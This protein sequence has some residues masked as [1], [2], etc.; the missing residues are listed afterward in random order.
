MRGADS[1]LLLAAAAGLAFWHF[2]LRPRGQVFTDSRQVDPAR[3]LPS[4]RRGVDP[5][6][7][8]AWPRHGIDPGR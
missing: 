5:G 7:M 2:Y 8:L 6:A 4:P 3:F 1:K